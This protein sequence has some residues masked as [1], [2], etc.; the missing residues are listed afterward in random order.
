VSGE[1]DV[2]G[3]RLVSSSRLPLTAYL[4]LVAAC[5]QSPEKQQEKIQQQ[6]KSWDA[7]ERLTGELSD[8]GA[9]PALYVRQVHEAAEQARKKAQQ[10]AAKIRQ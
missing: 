6:L 10:Q 5:H 2:R 4:L 3:K 8:R 7:T 9:L 1:R